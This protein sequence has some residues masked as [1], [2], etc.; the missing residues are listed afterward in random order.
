MKLPWSKKP[1]D[2]YLCTFVVQE[3][4]ATGEKGWGDVSE[5]TSQPPTKE[6]C[7]ELFSPGS[8]YQ[9]MARYAEGP[10][11]GQFAGVVWHHFEPLPGGLKPKPKEK[12]KI[13]EKVVEK[14]PDYAE[15]MGKYADQVERTLD[16]LA[17][18]F[19]SLEAVRERLGGGVGVAPQPSAVVSEPGYSVPPPEF[20]GKL[21]AIMHPYVIHTIAE[22]LKSVVDFAGARFERV[23]RPAEGEVEEEEE[24]RLPTLP[25]PPSRELPGEVEEAVEEEELP[26]EEIE[27][28]VVEEEVEEE[29]LPAMPEVPEEKEVPEEEAEG[30]E[31]RA[32]LQCGRTDV[33]L[34]PSGLCEDCVKRL[35]QEEAE[36]EGEEEVES[37]D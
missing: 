30:E 19:E 22:E 32:C 10:K 29:E 24:V 7:H 15:V 35:A 3:F 9:C 27:E 2:K 26:E 34:L 8:S 23:L 5:P 1:W 13:R 4:G 25:M 33:A 11:A 28:E 18:L 12:G 31:E 16:P 21:P 37:E 14:E 6:E 36:V 20:D 17:R